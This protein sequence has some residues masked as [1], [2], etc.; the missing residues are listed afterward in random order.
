MAYS[1]C[2]RYSAVLGSTRQYSAVL[3]STRENRLFRSKLVLPRSSWFCSDTLI[4][5]EFCLES[6]EIFG[7]WGRIYII[8]ANVERSLGLTP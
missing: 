1:A 7:P 3:G 4:L 8:F 2:R 6:E 5:L